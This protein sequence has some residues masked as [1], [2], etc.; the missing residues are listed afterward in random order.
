MHVEDLYGNVYEA[1]IVK[2]GRKYVHVAVKF[3][4][5][6]ETIPFDII[7]ERTSQRYEDDTNAIPMYLIG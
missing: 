5:H 3:T 6:T 2:R 4:G 1:K 7:T